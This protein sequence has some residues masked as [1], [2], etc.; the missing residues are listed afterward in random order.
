[1]HSSKRK[2]AVTEGKRKITA[3]DKAHTS[4]KKSVGKKKSASVENDGSYLQA[5]VSHSVPVSTIPPSAHTNIS[6][7]TGQAKLTMFT[8]TDTIKTYQDVW[9]SWSEMIA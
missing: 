9:I 7:S 4:I 2:S 6:A 1:M 5:H 3:S 8:Q